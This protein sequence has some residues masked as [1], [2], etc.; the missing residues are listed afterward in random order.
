MHMT[1]GSYHHLY[2]ICVNIVHVH[3]QTGEGKTW[4]VTSAHVN[5]IRFQL[6]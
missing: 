6:R 4:M 3:V 1:L 2:P 5:I